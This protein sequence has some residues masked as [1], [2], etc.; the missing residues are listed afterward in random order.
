MFTPVEDRFE[1]SVGSPAAFYR[2]LTGVDPAAADIAADAAFDRHVFACTLA[3]ALSEGGDLAARLGLAPAALEAL[4]EAHFPHVRGLTLRAAGDA[5]H[6]DEAAM[7]RDLLVAHRSQPGR[8][9][10]W[11]AAIVARRAVEPN[12]LWEDLG[13]NARTELT[14][15]LERHFQPLAVRNTGNMRWKR[16]FYRTLCE[17]DG[18]V[19]CTTPVCSACGDFESCFGEETGESRLARIRRASEVV[20]I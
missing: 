9:T 12:H 7:V 1:R 19:M 11:L 2:R 15:L 3:V 20:R 4:A 5:A 18:L 13:L 6:D 17:A 10:L 8:D 16:F 14:R